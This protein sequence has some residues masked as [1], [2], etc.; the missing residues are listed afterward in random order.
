MYGPPLL[1]RKRS[2]RE[3]AVD[4]SGRHSTP[5]Q[6]P[7]E[8]R[9]EFGLDEKIEAGSQ[10]LDEAGDD[11]GE[12]ERRITVVCHAGQPL[13]HGF[14][15]SLGHCRDHQAVRRMTAMELVDERCHRHHFTERDGVDPDDW[16]GWFVWSIWL[17]R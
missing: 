4:E 5:T 7:Q 16:V 3:P 11:A 10:S 12:I 8:I 2:A 15:P 17:V 6:V 1:P 13:L 9:P 14:P